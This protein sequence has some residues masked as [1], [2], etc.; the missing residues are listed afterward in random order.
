M[1]GIKIVWGSASLMDEVAYPTLES[2]NETFDIL[3]SNGIKTIDTAKLYNNC[4]ELLGKV[5]ADS[6]FTIDS[7]YPGGFSPDPS[8]PESL[9][10]GLNESLARLQTNQVSLLLITQD[11]KDTQSLI[12]FLARCL[13]HACPRTQKLNGRSAG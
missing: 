7:K 1:A 5:H 11:R 4:E 6:R 13:L 10:T 3:Q 8:T 9:V 2:I 12:P